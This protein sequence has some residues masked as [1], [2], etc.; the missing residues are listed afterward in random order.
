LDQEVVSNILDEVSEEA[1]GTPLAS[2]EG[3]GSESPDIEV[4][5]VDIDII[6]EE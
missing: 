5:V 6:D 3:D 2:L 4:D 1:V